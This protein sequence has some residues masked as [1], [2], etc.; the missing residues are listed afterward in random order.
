MNKF[1]NIT[2]REVESSDLQIFYEDQLDPE[3]VR[4]AGFVGKNRTDQAVFDA[5]WHK[6]LNTPRITQRTIVADGQ[7][8]GYIGCFPDGENMEVTYWIGKEFWGKGLATKALSEMLH[9]VAD[10][11]IF[12]R[13][14]ADNIGSIRVL[15][16]CGFKMI[17]AN[18][19]FANGGGEETDEYVFC[20]D[21][22]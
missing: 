6:I 20:L 8:A 13:A 1:D 17:G 19:D 10:R 4:M 5:H 3:A 15:Q 21:H 2:L 7:V 16:K 11:P 14:V 12:A 22:D 18:K 9:L